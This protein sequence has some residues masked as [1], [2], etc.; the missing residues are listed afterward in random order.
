MDG[1]LLAERTILFQLQPFGIVL[2]IFHI[3][4]ISVF[5]FGAFKRD[6]GSVDGSHF[7]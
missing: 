6:L 4:V 2:L 7:F 1:M 3:V 5:A